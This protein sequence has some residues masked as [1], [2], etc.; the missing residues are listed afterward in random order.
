MVGAR[1]ACLG[2]GS[3]VSVDDY[4]VP[5]VGSHPWR[6]WWLGSLDRN[7]RPAR[8]TQ[9]ILDYFAL[10]DLRLPAAEFTKLEARY[11]EGFWQL[12]D[13]SRQPSGPFP[14]EG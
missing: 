1:G 13:R 6:A 9:E 10:A 5:V 12:V 4:G 8:S 11:H 7:R 14:R 2:W 3:A